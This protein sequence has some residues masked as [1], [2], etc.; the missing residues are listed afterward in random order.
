MFLISSLSY[1][2]QKFP[3][4]LTHSLL[5]GGVRSLS[6]D[7]QTDFG[8]VSRAEVSS[9]PGTFFSRQNDAP[10]IPIRRSLNNSAIRVAHHQP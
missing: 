1:Q 10:D 9:P 2:K 6:K 5:D 8:E 4:W 3:L 7:W